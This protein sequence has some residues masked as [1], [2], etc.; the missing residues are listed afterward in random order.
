MGV[1]GAGGSSLPEPQADL[2]R[3]GPVVVGILL[4]GGELKGSLAEGRPAQPKACLEVAGTSLLEHTLRPLCEAQSL[5]SIVVVGPA[6][7]EHVVAATAPHA[8]WAES[9][10]SLVENLLQGVAEAPEADYVLA[11]SA[12]LPLLDPTEV[13]F[14]VGQASTREAEFVYSMVERRVCGAAYPGTERTC[15]TIREGTFTG[16]NIMLMS[17]AMVQRNAQL[18]RDVFELRKKP[19]SLCRMLGWTFVLRLLC[20]RLTADQASERVGELLGCRAT[21]V[22]AGASVAFDVDKPADLALA[23]QL[24]RQPEAS[25]ATS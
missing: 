13:D 4:A 21:V 7:M 20:H 6:E 9:G 15:V 1:G 16:G 17:R 10:D 8:R 18:I 23:E 14:F 12:D 25:A 22:R 5:S 24:L 2:P 3:N 11:V 19:W